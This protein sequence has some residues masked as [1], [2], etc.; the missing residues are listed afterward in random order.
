[1]KAN[2][3]REKFLEFF[4]SKDH[5]V[6][7]S[8]SLIPEN[9]PTVLF[10]TAGMHPLV[11]YL[12]GENHPEGKR[13]VNSQKCIRTGDI[14]EVGNATHHTFFE[15]LGNW[16]LGDYWKK[17]S[18]TWSME[19]LTSNEWLNLEKDKIAVSVFEGDDTAPFDEESFNIWKELGVDEKRI[20]KLSKKDNWWG[21]A[22]ETGP[23]GPDSEM[24][25]WVG[26]SDAP[27]NFDTEDKNWVEIW[28][29]VFMEY[30]ETLDGKFE[31]L[32]QKNVDTGMGLSRVLTV[33]NASDDNYTTDLYEPL[34]E[35][36]EKLS[37]KKY[38]GNEKA[39]RII[40]D[41]IKAATFIIAEGIIPSNKDQGYV[42]RRL[43]RRAIVKANQLGIKNNF[44]TK[45]ANSIHDIYS[46][47]YNLDIDKTNIELDKE[48]EK[49][50]KT[51]E[52]GI[53]L[54]ESMKEIDGKTMFDLYQTYGIPNEVVIEEATLRG[55]LVT[56]E[57]ISDAK[58]RFLKH[59]DLSRT[60]SEGKF[61]GGL[62]DATEDTKKLHTAAHLLLAALK[63]VLGDDV[64]QKGS[65]ITAERLRFDF[66]HSEKLT[67]EERAEVEKLVNDVI[68]QDLPVVMEE[69]SLDD[70]K[71]S[72]ATGTFSDKYGDKVKVYTVAH[73][74][75]DARSGSR[76]YFSK[77]ICGGPH[78]KKTG[79]LGK[80]KIKKE[81]SSSSG[82]RRIKAVLE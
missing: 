51:L 70:A 81:Q 38:R 3:L 29:D 49:F 16:S 43:I 35:K 41:H 57:S 73:S 68:D 14:D 79:D 47:V 74:T 2:L 55:K 53:S 80:F 75:G 15:M 5:K 63:K 22:G 26:K 10:T 44:T 27:E 8:A 7:P 19:F 42:V 20:A 23:C 40:S 78:T 69:M 1:M 6:I 36:I 67:D 21:P 64:E 62:A 39:M 59:Q 56:K 28:N 66:S 4:K 11:P 77:E 25:Y 12:M 33:I 65:N 30:N 9:D 34:I 45:L 13:L 18:L 17:E 54:L 82:V 31:P 71:K 61:K 60:A 46:G 48:E 52:K 76:E 58:E 24:F 72:G 32:S 50:R 37:G